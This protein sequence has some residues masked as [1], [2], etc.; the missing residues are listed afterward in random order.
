M[1]ETDTVHLSK[2]VSTM[3][4][5]LPPQGRWCEAVGVDPAERA[6]ELQA[7]RGDHPAQQRV[8][9]TKSV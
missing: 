1:R 9:D 8:A 5:Y 3:A 7:G 4:Q 6:A 2:Y